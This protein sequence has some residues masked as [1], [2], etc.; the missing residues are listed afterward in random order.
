M[1]LLLDQLICLPHKSCHFLQLHHHPVIVLTGGIRDRQL[2]TLNGYLKFEKNC[3]KSL[4]LAY[5]GSVGSLLLRLPSFITIRT[6]RGE[7]QAFSYE[8]VHYRVYVCYKTQ[9]IKHHIHL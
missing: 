6:L 9:A 4:P 8:H 7:K 1:D 2:K 3:L 5:I